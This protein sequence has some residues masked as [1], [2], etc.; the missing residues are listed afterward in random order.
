MSK[1]MERFEARQRALGRRD[2]LGQAPGTSLGESGHSPLSDEERAKALDTVLGYDRDG[3]EIKLSAFRSEGYRLFARITS[4]GP[5]GQ[6]LIRAL[7]IAPGGD[8]IAEA[9]A[10]GIDYA[11][12]A[13]ASLAQGIDPAVGLKAEIEYRQAVNDARRAAGGRPKF[14]K[15]VQEPKP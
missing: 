11:A 6:S 15:P 8:E 5:E 14:F 3:Q 12:V 1:M 4:P 13:R 2:D 9:D 7:S 10:L